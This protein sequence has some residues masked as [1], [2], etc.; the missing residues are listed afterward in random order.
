MKRCPTCNSTFDEEHLNYCITDGTALVRDED[1]PGFELQ[2]TELLSEPPVTL[3]MPPRPAEYVAQVADAPTPPAP[4]GWANESPPAW[5]PPPPPVP[6]GRAGRPAQQ[7]GIAVASLI[8]GL[9]SITF[10]WICG[11]P[12]FGLLAV[13][14]GVV[15]LTMI[16]RNPQQY[17]GKPIALA[18][19]ITGGIALLVNLAIMAIWIVMMIVGAATN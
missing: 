12:I 11:G 5:V 13:V 16:K 14:L 18:G 6:F 3:V 17:G 7:Q 15:A 10:G 1:R 9:I 19:L 2:E 4:Y 8:L